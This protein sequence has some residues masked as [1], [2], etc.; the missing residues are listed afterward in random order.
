MRNQV[1]SVKSVRRFKFKEEDCIIPWLGG[2]CWAVD[3]VIVARD[4]A[5]MD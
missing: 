4:V 5:V 1:R 3:G 2:G